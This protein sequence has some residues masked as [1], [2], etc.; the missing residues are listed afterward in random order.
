M[1]CADLTKSQARHQ[2]LLRHATTT[3]SCASSSASSSSWGN[4]AWQRAGPHPPPTVA[5]CWC[6]RRLLRLITRYHKWLALAGGL[7]LRNDDG[8]DFW[9]NRG[10]RLL[11]CRTGR[12][13][14]T[15]RTRSRS[16]NVISQFR[17]RWR[18]MQRA[19]ST[20]SSAATSTTPNP[21]PARHHLSQLRRTGWKAVPPGRR[22]HASVDHPLG[23]AGASQQESCSLPP[24]K[25]ATIAA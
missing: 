10:R 25:R 22:L 17:M 1:W 24:L 3:S 5:S 16:V 13:R 11:A 9:F 20:A 21:R 18:A 14:P 12:C 8:G 23:R 4:I 19:A 15:P 2:G 6:A 7:R